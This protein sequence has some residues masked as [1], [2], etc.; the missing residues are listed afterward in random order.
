MTFG[1]RMGIAHIIQTVY[2]SIMRSKTCPI[3][4][5][6]EYKQNSERFMEANTFSIHSHSDI[7]LGF[8]E[9][10]GRIIHRQG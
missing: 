5:R 4:G 10:R 8:P 7:L 9:E 2:C 1:K 6:M 3:I